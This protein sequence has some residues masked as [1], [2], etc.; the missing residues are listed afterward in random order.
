ME[1]LHAWY[2]GLMKLALVSLF[3]EMSTV[4]PALQKWYILRLKGK[5][6]GALH[7]KRP[8]VEAKPAKGTL[9]AKNSFP[10]AKIEARIRHLQALSTRQSDR[11]MPPKTPFKNGVTSMTRLNA[12]EQPGLCIHADLHS[13]EWNLPQL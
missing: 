9:G 13:H 8:L 12:Q 6:G 4:S 5:P 3:F 1:V 10:K 11:S 2:L 7:K